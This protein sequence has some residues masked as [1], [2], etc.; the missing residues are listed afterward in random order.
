[1]T[2]LAQLVFLRC[3][4]YSCVFR[5]RRPVNLHHQLTCPGGDN[6]YRGIDSSGDVVGSLQ[7]YDERSRSRVPSQG[8]NFTFFDYP[9]APS[10]FA[11]GINVPA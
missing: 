10:T 2:H 6:K 1:M 9:G 11:T 4:C 7:H 8:G 3:F 5:W